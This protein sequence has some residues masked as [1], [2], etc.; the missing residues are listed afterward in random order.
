MPWKMSLTLLALVPWSLPAVIHCGDRYPFGK[1]SWAFSSALADCSERLLWTSVS[2][3]LKI[4][5][6][7]WVFCVI[8]IP[9]KSVLHLTFEFC[10]TCSWVTD[11]QRYTS[12]VECSPWV[13]R[14]LGGSQHIINLSWWHSWSLSTWEVKAGKAKVQSHSWLYNT[15]RGQPGLK[16]KPVLKLVWCK[17]RVGGSQAWSHLGNSKEP[18]LE[19]E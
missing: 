8:G 7:S 12:V 5:S 9:T 19:M 4:T 14:G 3:T 15:F 13:C 16:N 10:G 18:A 6:S 1:T 2:V 11:K 17:D